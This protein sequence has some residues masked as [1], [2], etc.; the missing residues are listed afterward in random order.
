LNIPP[1]PFRNLA[2]TPVPIQLGQD[3]ILWAGEIGELLLVKRP[4]PGD[5]DINLERGCQVN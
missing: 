3:R 2:A 1:L 4:F 5:K